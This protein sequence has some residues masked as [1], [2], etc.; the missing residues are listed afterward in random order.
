MDDAYWHSRIGAL[1]PGQLD[2]W[3]RIEDDDD[4][5]DVAKAV[6]ADIREFALRAIQ[7]R[8]GHDGDMANPS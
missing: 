6:V 1:M 8:I 5:S 3:W 4:A 2:R 7:Q